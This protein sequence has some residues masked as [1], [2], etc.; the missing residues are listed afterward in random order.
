MYQVSRISHPVHKCERSRKSWIVFAC[1]SNPVIDKNP[2]SSF[3]TYP[4][5]S[6][7]S[8]FRR[9]DPRK[10]NYSHSVDK[11]KIQTFCLSFF[12]LWNMQVNI[13]FCTSRISCNIC[14]QNEVDRTKNVRYCLCGFLIFSFICS[15]MHD[16]RLQ[17]NNIHNITWYS[18]REYC[19]LSSYNAMYWLQF[20]WP[21]SV[22][23]F[24]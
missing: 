18:S 24:L 11:V 19:I 15:V 9:R 21:H 23:E 1:S 20:Y 16:R 3:T 22:S 4:V 14:R 10:Y 17:D 13:I 5:F 7:N 8:L 2:V 12:V 6:P